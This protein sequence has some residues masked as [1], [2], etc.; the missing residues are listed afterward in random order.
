MAD[1]EWGDN[2]F[3]NATAFPEQHELIDP[4]TGKVLDW[5]DPRGGVVRMKREIHN[6]LAGPRVELT[7]ALPGHGAITTF[8]RRPGVLVRSNTTPLEPITGHA[9]HTWESWDVHPVMQRGPALERRDDSVDYWERKHEHF[10]IDIAC[11]RCHPKPAR[12]CRRGRNLG[13]QALKFSEVMDLVW[14]ALPRRN[15][16]VV[17]LTVQELEQIATRHFQTDDE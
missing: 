13:M 16:D 4:G 11:A 1:R 14:F 8:V 17:R 2:D 12:G 7:C 10:T 5:D 3:E 15:G 6:S 9:G